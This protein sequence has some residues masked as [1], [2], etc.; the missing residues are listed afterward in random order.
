MVSTTNHLSQLR[1]TSFFHHRPE[2]AEI[3]GDNTAPVWGGWG[4]CFLCSLA[5][6]S[7]LH[8]LYKIPKAGA[9]VLWVSSWRCCTKPRVV[10]ADSQGCY[11]PTF[12]CTQ[13]AQHWAGTNTQHLQRGGGPTQGWARG[14]GCARKLDT[15]WPGDVWSTSLPCAVNQSQHELK[16]SPKIPGWNSA[17]SCLPVALSSTKP[18]FSQRGSGPQ[19]ALSSKP[20]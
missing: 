5:L 15:A 14:Q 6:C 12:T 13:R 4:S 16:Y 20:T 8:L 19:N 18:S 11:K 2:A 7:L 3:Q 9:V 10:L 1:N 17:L